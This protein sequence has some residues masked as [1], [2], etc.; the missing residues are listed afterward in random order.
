MRKG[1]GGGF[2]IEERLAVVVC[3]PHIDRPPDYVDLSRQIFFSSDLPYLAH[4]AEW[5][6]YN[7]NSLEQVS[8][9]GSVLYRPPTTSQN[10]MLRSR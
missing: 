3:I 7:L 8:W 6:P 5:K 9:V 2:G 10:G 4:V 1:G